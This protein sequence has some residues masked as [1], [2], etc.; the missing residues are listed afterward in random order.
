MT[1][2]ELP[3]IPHEM[4][5]NLIHQRA[6]D[7]Y[8]NATAMCNAAHKKISHYLEVK[9]TQD[10]LVE[11][12]TDTK[13]PVDALVQTMKGGNPQLQGTWVHPQVAIHLAQWLSAKFAVQVAKWVYE[14]LSGG[15]VAGKKSEMPVHLQRYMANLSEIPRTHFSILNEITF[16]LIAP[17]E[18]SGYTLPEHLVPDISEGRMFSDWLRKEKGLDPSTFPTYRHRYMDGRTVDARLY[19]NELLAEFRAHFHEVWLPGKAER[20]F[21]DRDEKALQY[22]PKLLPP[23]T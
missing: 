21:K 3:V 4:E 8:I 17:L 1:Q 10:F 23:A 6:S 15:V 12:S 22:L 16:A 18:A 11:L 14:W 20:Y 2:L 9:A 7:G 5:G 19:P 13:I